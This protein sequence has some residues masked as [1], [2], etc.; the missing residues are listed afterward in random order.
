MNIIIKGTKPQFK[1][2]KMIE[3]VENK[4]YIGKTKKPSK[5]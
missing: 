1:I 4:F 2:Y 5:R 3:T